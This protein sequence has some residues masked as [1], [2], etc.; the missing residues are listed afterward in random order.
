MADHER[1]RG[2]ANREDSESNQAW[3][4]RQ[5]PHRRRKLAALSN[6]IECLAKSKARSLGLWFTGSWG[7][8]TPQDK[9]GDSWNSDYY[10]KL[11]RLLG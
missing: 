11:I 2:R 8:T 6:S 4:K 1:R 3:K 7:R 5:R 9:N 10:L